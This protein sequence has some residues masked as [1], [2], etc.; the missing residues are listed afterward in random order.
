MLPSC[1]MNDDPIY[2]ISFMNQGEVYEI[3]ARNVGQGEMFAFIEVEELI[4]GERS[5]ILIDSSEDR[6][7]NEFKGVRRTFIPI[8]SIIRIDQVDR[9]GSGRIRNGEGKVSTFPM[10]LIAPRGSADKS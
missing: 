9:A 1:L 3:Y 10:P 8:H 5:Q 2:R 6:L 4:F 7:K